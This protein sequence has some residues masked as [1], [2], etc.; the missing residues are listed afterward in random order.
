MDPIRPQLDY[1]RFLDEGRFMLQRSRTSGEFVFYPRVAEPRT[2]STDLEWVEATGRG[3]VYSATVVR[4][5]PPNEPYNVVLVDLEEGVRM[6]SRV[7][8]IAPDDVRIGMAVR[9]FVV[10][11]GD[12][13]VV[14]FRPATA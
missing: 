5:S 1:Q 6:M 13:G 11:E 2:G 7:D 14:V 8:G 9:A 3:H 4:K 12:K 10:Q